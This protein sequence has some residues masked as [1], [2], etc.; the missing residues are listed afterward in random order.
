MTTTVFFRAATLAATADPL[1][2]TAV[3]ATPFPVQRRDRRGPLLEVLN[4]HGAQAATDPLPVQLDHRTSARETIGT[5]SNIRVEEDQ[6]L[7]DIRL[8][9]AD[10]AEPIR[11]RIADGTL[12]TFSVGYTVSRSSET[13]DADGNRVVTV[14]SFRVMEISLTPI[15][16]DPN[17]RKRSETTM[18]YDIET[19]EAL[20]DDL[21]ERCKLP[22]DWGQD[23]TEEA[24]TDDEVRSAALEA[25]LTR[26]T[27]TIRVTRSHDDPQAIVSRAAAGVYARMSGTEIPEA[28]RDYANMSLMDLAKDSLSRAGVSHR[29]MSVDEVLHRSVAGTSDFPAIVA[30]VANMSV[31][32][33]YRV[34]ESPLKVL[35]KRRSLSDFKVAST[36]RAGGLGRLEP[37]TE[38]GEITATSRAEEAEPLQLRTFARRW[39]CSRTLII[40]D[41]LNILADTT[42]Q[43]GESAAATEADLCADQLLGT[44][45]LS[46]GTPLFDASR[47]NVHTGTADL[48]ADLAAAR[49]IMRQ[50]KNL[51]GITPIS[52]SPKYI[53]AGPSRETDLEQVLATIYANTTADANVFAGKFQLLIDPRIE[54]DD[55]FLFA[56]PARAAVFNLGHL[57]AAPGPQVQRQETWSTLGISFRCWMD[58]GAGFAGW[59]GAVKVTG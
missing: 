25:M 33:A 26:Q 56:D 24:V 35:F 5:A 36:V 18:P 23:L 38:H 58:V 30:N 29:G 48:V 9:T 14:S 28:S 41:S 17:A 45:T 16:A 12:S 27:P 34:A 32:Q 55:W 1:T 31:G 19:R 49:L 11:Q 59:R 37:L 7:A 44:D 51:D 53:V 39:D 46:D 4:P 22:D 42:S 3:I 20:I 8:T 50:Q 15:P 6:L 43:L 52:V 13:R 2:F 57:A 54:T 40:N 21:R 47:N 10:D